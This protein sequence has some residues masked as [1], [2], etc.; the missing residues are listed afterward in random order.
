[1]QNKK[2]LS[3]RIANMNDVVGAVC[4]L[5]MMVL[6]AVEVILRSI[7]DVSTLVSDEYSG[8]LMVFI[9]Y[10]GAAGAFH[11]GSFVR[12]TAIFGRLKPK[13]Q[14]VLNII[15][16][17]LFL[18][19]NTMLVYF[20]SNSVISVVKYHSIAS[21]VARTPLWIP[22]G[23]CYLGLIFFEVYLI[24]AFIENIIYKKDEV[25]PV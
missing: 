25:T 3:E 4:I 20:F 12:V 23:I 8:Y 14:K 24:C 5:I 13:V 17:V 11:S 21:T 1:M 9:A 10:W 7:F 18:A 6:I 16:Q 22:Y 15:Y 19:F 2:R